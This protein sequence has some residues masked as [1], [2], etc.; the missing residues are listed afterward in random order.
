MDALRK[1]YQK[2]AQKVLEAPQSIGHELTYRILSHKAEAITECLSII[3][4]RL[5]K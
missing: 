5:E 1:Y 3:K 2:K 4:E